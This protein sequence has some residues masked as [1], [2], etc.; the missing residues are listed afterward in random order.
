LGAARAPTL[1]PPFATTTVVVVADI[2]ILVHVVVVL[3]VV[4]VLYARDLT[5]AGRRRALDTDIINRSDK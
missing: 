1:A 5:N 2:I 3:T 4:A